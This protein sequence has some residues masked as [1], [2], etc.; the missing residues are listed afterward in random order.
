VGQGL[1]KPFVFSF[2]VSLIGCFYGLRTSGGTQ[3]VGR[4]TT[5]AMVAASVAIFFLDLFISKIF[6][7][8]TA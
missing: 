5:Q 8:R 2:A 1:L 7:S 6:V 3:G 4:S